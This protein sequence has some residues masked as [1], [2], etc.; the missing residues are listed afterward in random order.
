MVPQPIGY[1]VPVFLVPGAGFVEDSFSMDW[2]GSGGWFQ[3]NSSVLHLLCSL[4][5]LLL[6]CDV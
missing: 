4:F 2:G 5:L 6:H 3:G 1:T